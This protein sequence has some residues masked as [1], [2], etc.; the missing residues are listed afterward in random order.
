[1]FKDIDWDYVIVVGFVSVMLGLVCI[2]FVGA[3]QEGSR[4]YETYLEYKNHQDSK[5]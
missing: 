1:M 4:N 5:R 2:G 3:A